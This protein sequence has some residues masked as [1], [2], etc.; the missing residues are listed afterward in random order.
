MK[1]ASENVKHIN[2]GRS[3]AITEGRVD[4]PPRSRK[5]KRTWT[6]TFLC[7]TKQRPTVFETK[8]DLDKV[9]VGKQLHGHSRVKNM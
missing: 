5:G 3:F 8:V 2:C 1:D 7:P 6:R 4:T 9:G